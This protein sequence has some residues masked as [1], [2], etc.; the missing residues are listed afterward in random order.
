MF[1]AIVSLTVEVR[2]SGWHTSGQRLG[3]GGDPIEH[4]DVRFFR[5]DGAFVATH[6]VYCTN[7]HYQARLAMVAKHFTQHP[8]A[9]DDY[10]KVLEV[11]RGYVIFSNLW[12]TYLIGQE[13]MVAS[14]SLSLDSCPCL[15]DVDHIP[16][17][18]V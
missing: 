10:E 8:A 6:H 14:I 5:P 7:E 1:T 18:T 11:E 2:E 3:Y 17:R 4:L 15:I 9:F 13:P 12:S 16:R